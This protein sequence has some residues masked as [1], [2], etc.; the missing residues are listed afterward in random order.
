MEQLARRALCHAATEPCTALQAQWSRG[1]SPSPMSVLTPPGL[2]RPRCLRLSFVQR[3]AIVSTAR[4]RYV[5]R[6]HI[7]TPLAAPAAQTVHLAPPDMPAVRAAVGVAVSLLPLVSEIRLVAWSCSAG[8]HHPRANGHTLIGRRCGRGYH[9]PHRAAWV[10]PRPQ[11]R[12]AQS[13]GADRCG[14]F[15]HSYRRPPTTRTM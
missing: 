6:A 7:V 2:Q 1:E 11:H 3:A 4:C 8:H 13:N 5:R 10:L 15:V 9:G 12:G 14:H